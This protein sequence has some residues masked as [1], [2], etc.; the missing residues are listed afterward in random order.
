[1]E[2]IKL[3][4]EA[5]VAVKKDLANI[6][7]KEDEALNTIGTSQSK[8]N[9]LEQDIKA[10]Q[11]KRDELDLQ[12]RNER[13]NMI[14]D[15]DK[16]TKEVE[17]LKAQLTVELTRAKDLSGKATYEITENKKSRNMADEEKQSYMEKRKELEAKLA[18]LD[19][20]RSVLSK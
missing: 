17:S 3:M 8:K 7:H 9:L 1:M 20:M 10:L 15:I 16:K 5:L 4:E 2:S 6:K 12:V 13:K 19:E 11:S 18:Q 14:D